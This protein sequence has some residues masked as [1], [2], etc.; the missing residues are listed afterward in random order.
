MLLLQE[1]TNSAIISE[2]IKY[3]PFLRIREKHTR[4][5]TKK[6]SRKSRNCLL[7]ENKQFAQFACK[8]MIKS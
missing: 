5:T 8:E 6:N 1:S 3:K 7:W 2:S 4:T